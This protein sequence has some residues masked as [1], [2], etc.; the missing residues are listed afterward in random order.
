MSISIDEAVKQAFDK[1]VQDFEKDCKEHSG[2]FWNE[3]TL[4]MDFFRH[5]SEL[6]LNMARFF[7]EFPITLWGKK[8]IPDL[9]V[10]FETNDELIMVAF[11][12]KFYLRGWK[13]DWNKIKN[14]LEEGFSYGYFLA[15]GTKAVDDLPCVEEKIGN[16]YAKAFVHYKDSQ[17]AFGLVPAFS[18]VEN[19]LKKTLDMPYTVSIMLQFSATIPEDYNILYLAQEDRILL[20]ANFYTHENDWSMIERELAKLGFTKFMN[21]K[22]DDWTFEPTQAFNGTVLLAELPTNSYNSTVVRAK[23]ALTKLRSLLATMKPPFKP[24]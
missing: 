15:I 21:L 18:V 3:D 9:V 24:K 17:E 13:E 10:H 4:K 6:G 11:E 7:S 20:L 14:Y 19:L 2:R 1:T 12:F 22:E 23:E 8:H 5:F 16:Y